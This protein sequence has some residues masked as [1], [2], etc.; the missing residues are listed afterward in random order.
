MDSK[1]QLAMKASNSYQYFLLQSKSVKKNKTMFST[2]NTVLILTYT[3]I[4]SF[5]LCFGLILL[6]FSFFYVLKFG[7]AHSNCQI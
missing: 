3:G 5:L 7:L 6:T 1:V 4:R 2:L